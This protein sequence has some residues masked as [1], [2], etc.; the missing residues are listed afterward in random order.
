[1]RAAAPR[2]AAEDIARVEQLGLRRLLRRR[3]RPL[4]VTA[5]GKPGAWPGEA[6][7]AFEGVLCFVSFELELVGYLAGFPFGAEPLVP[8]G[9]AG[10]L[11]GLAL[12]Y[13]GP[14]LSLLAQAHGRLLGLYQRRA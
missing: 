7:S 4:I 6:W 8:G 9:L 10:V 5:A 12:H 3:G 13:L 11:P 1:M 2:A 14:V